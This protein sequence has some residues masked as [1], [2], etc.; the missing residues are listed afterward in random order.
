MF[1]A[2]NDLRSVQ[3]SASPFPQKLGVLTVF[4]VDFCLVFE[5]IEDF[6]VKHRYTRRYSGL[7]FR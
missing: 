3:R 1:L 6:D 2:L 4:R 5:I 7:V